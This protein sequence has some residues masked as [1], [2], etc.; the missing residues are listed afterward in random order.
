MAGWTLWVLV[1][2]ISLRAEFLQSRLHSAPEKG[3]SLLH[4]LPSATS[5]WGT[6]PPTTPGLGAN[7]T[8]PPSQSWLGPMAEA[9]QVPHV[10]PVRAAFIVSH[11]PLPNA[12]H[13]VILSPCPDFRGCCLC[14]LRAQ[15]CWGLP[16]YATS[17]WPQRTFNA[18]WM[19]GRVGV[20]VGV[21]ET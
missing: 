13:F 11:C 17:A 14:L 20:G 2:L 9:R 4:G 3:S 18:R 15:R 6:L 21:D 1:R 10:C 8:L 19:S 16:A 7:V 5:A 12:H